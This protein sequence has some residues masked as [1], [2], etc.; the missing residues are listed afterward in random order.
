MQIPVLATV[1]MSVRPSVRH[2]L[3]LCEN[4]AARITKSSPTDSLRTLVFAMNNSSSDSRALNESGIGKIRNFQQISRRITETVQ[5]RTLDQ[6]Y[7]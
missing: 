7:C 3:A 2:T 1:G 5:D 6:S 4:H